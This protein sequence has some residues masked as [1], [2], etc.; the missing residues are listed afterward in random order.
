MIAALLQPQTGVY[1]GIPLSLLFP[2]ETGR[3]FSNMFGVVTD[4]VNF[5]PQWTISIIGGSQL[6][7]LEVDICLPIWL[8]EWTTFAY[9]SATAPVSPTDYLMTYLAVPLQ[10][11]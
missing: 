3:L 8:Q 7:L 9:D 2:S 11:L 1:D 6:S 5:E 4:A 10:W